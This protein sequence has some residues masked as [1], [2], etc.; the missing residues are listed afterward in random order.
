M[1][2]K[3]P[4]LHHGH[5]KR[6]KEQ[7]LAA[8]V[9]GLLHL[10]EHEPLEFLLYYAIPRGD[11][12]A[13]AH[14]LIK[15][16]G[17]L[18]NVVNASYD[19]LRKVAG[20]GDNAASLICYSQMFAKLYL[21]KHS[22]GELQDKFNVPRLKEYCQA[23]FIGVLA[24]EIHCVFLTDELKLIAREKVGTGSIGEVVLPTRQIA[25]SLLNYNCSRLVLAHNHPA[26]SCLPSRADIDATEQLRST[27]V[28]LEVELVDHIVV[29]RDGVTSMRECGFA[30]F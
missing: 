11:T 30:E 6:K 10:P 14:T 22:G 15:H 16:F 25:R 2:E 12:N 24:E 8:G 5:R 28:Q 21:Q 20:V 3:Q 1:N 23:L 4:H 13:V 27:C 29:G 26:G 9:D 17:S 18:A 19:E 7:F